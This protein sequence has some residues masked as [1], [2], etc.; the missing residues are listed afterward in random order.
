M[1]HR[2]TQYIFIYNLYYDFDANPLMN[3][4][5]IKTMSNQQIKPHS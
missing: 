2:H 1:Q 5:N 3:G 4:E